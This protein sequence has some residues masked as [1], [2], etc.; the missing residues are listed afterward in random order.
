MQ[1]NQQ[2]CLYYLGQNERKTERG[3]VAWQKK[4]CGDTTKLTAEAAEV[5][6]ESR[7]MLDCIM[8]D[9]EW[10]PTKFELL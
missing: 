4:A 6:L 2:R 5:I 3:V 8:H 9:Q 1:E 7:K 10:N